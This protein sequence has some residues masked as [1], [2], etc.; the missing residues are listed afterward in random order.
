MRR[1]LLILACLAIALPARTQAPA[2]ASDA[3]TAAALSKATAD[4]QATAS[5]IRSPSTSD[6]VLRAR[7]A[8]I[9]SI[10]AQLNQVLGRLTPRLADVDARLAQLGPTPGPGQ[11]PDAP[12]TAAARAGLLHAHQAVDADIKRA[13]LLTVEAAQTSKAISNQLRSNVNARLLARSRSI[14]DPRLVS[15]LD[16]AI[17]KEAARVVA[18]FE[19]EGRH[20]GVVAGSPHGGLILAFGALAAIFLIGPARLLLNRADYWR[21]AAEGSESRLRQSARAVW[22]VLVATVTPLLAGLALRVAL[23]S[24]GALDADFDV[25]L[26]ILIR[27]VAVTSLIEAL[28]R[29]LLS[30]GTPT[31]R[32]APIPDDMAARLAPYPALIGVA[33][34]LALLVSAIDF[35]IGPGLA[36]SA[37]G[38]RITVVIEILAV[39]SAL[40]AVMRHRGPREVRPPSASGPLVVESRLFWVLTVLAAWVALTVAL[41]AL[42][43]GYVA[44]AGF[45]MRETIW[46]TTVLATLFLS[47]VFAD[48]IFPALLSPKARL[49]RVLR[50]GVGIHDESLEHLA[51]LLSGLSRL[52]LLL[53]GWA[54]ILLPFGTSAGDIVARAT[55]TQTEFKIG[56]ATI[57]PGAVFGAIGLFLVALAITRAVRGWLEVRYLPK[58]K[59]D[60]GVRTS[61]SA[62]FSYVGGA[63]ALLLAFAYLGLSF[64]QIALFASALSVGIGFG[65]QSIISNFVSGLILLVERP[66]KV[67]DWIAIGGSG[68]RC[69]GDQ[70]P[71]HRDRHVGQV[72]ANRPQFGTSVKDRPQCH[73]RRGAG[74]GQDR[75]AP[76]QRGRSSR[77]ARHRSGPPQGSSENPGLAWSGR[78]LHRHP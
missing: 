24:A 6:E 32:L 34:G 30:P 70:Y 8:A 17:A 54:A 3:A 71:R 25:V 72:K 55:S 51:V 18:I 14:F 4:L 36:T 12:A 78:L 57:S 29:E 67:G 39:G 44:L 63:I 33:G 41:V 73:S 45:L 68:G 46:I 15:G 47:L 75:A 38:E 40:L 48:E 77:G 26:V 69:A 1:L 60:R 11:P 43:I 27:V 13:N 53:F 76:R 65:L 59:M 42:V 10:Q 49:G 2:P 64:S 28:G 22:L 9:P 20:I 58:T 31:W 7:L 21:S 23:S 5:G 62:L 50:N 56:Q 74:Q 19:Q 66:V 61:V 35:A 52:G 37:A 16:D